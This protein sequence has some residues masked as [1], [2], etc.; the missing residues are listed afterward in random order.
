M[1]RVHC[2]GCGVAAADAPRGRAPAD[3]ETKHVAQRH[4]CPGCR[5]KR[6]ACREMV[7]PGLHDHA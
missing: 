1:L 4:L 3:W 6:D 7:L 2:D 5:E